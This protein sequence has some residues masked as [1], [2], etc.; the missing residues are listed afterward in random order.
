MDDGPPDARGRAAEKAA[1]RSEDRR[2]LEAGEIDA[3]GLARRN[4]FFSEL[5]V[6]SWRIV[7]IGGRDPS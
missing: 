2:R 5:D 4:E 6:A 7:S 3:E 1:G